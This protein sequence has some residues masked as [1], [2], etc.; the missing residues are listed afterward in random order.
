MDVYQNFQ[1]L[2]SKKAENFDKLWSA[3]MKVQFGRQEKEVLGAMPQKATQADKDKWLLDKKKQRKE[4]KKEFTP[5]QSEIVKE[6][7]KEGYALIGM[8]EEI[9]VSNPVVQEYLEKNTFNFS[10]SITDETNLKLG[11][12]LSDGIKDGESIPQLRKRVQ[13]VFKGMVKYRSEMI[14]RTETIKATNWGTERAYKESGVVK[15]KIWLTAMDERVCE[16]CGPMDGKEVSLDKS[17]FDKGDTAQGREG[18]KLNLDYDIVSHPPLHPNC[19]CTIIP[20]V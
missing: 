16:F 4:M 20:K 17:F 9:D 8:D 11:K 2:Q 1:K 15:G 10:D 19:R 3:K 7:S 14:A 5:L 13:G 12:S 6:G 18:G